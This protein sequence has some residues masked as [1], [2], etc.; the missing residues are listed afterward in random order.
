MSVSFS[1]QGSPTDNGNITFDEPGINVASNFSLPR[2]MV[3]FQ[4]QYFTGKVNQ[5]SLSDAAI[6]RGHFDYDVP[7]SQLK[8]LWFDIDA[9][10]FGDLA[11]SFN[12]TAPLNN[13]NYE[14]NPGTFFPSTINVPNAFSLKPVLRWGIGVDVGTTGPLDHSCN[15]SLQI[16][17]GHA[18]IDFMNSSRSH[19]TGWSPRLASSVNTREAASGHAS[20]Y[21]DFSI[22]LALDVM[23]G[24]FGVTGGVSARPQFINEF[25]LPQSHTRVRKAERMIWPRNVTC[26]NGFEL[27]SAF[28]FSV[29]AYVTDWWQ[30]DLYSTKIPIADECFPF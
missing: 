26:T 3:V 6:I 23:N 30:Q 7:S 9:A 19:A 22:E 25:N 8:S 15:M 1:T 17:D 5:G 29:K 28:N 2:D 18:H 27:Q 4:D 24:V 11:V 20:P 12:L 21:I 14:F 16:P 10:F 13:N